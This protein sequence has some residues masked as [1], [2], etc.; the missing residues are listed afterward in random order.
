MSTMLT[1]TCNLH[2]RLAA[3]T[4]YNLVR[5]IGNDLPGWVVDIDNANSY[6]AS[7]THRGCFISASVV[8]IN[9]DESS[10][11]FAI[12]SPGQIFDPFGQL[13][14]MLDQIVQPFQ[15]QASRLQEVERQKQIQQG[16]MCPKCNKP[17]PSGARFCPFDGTPIGHECP[18]CKHV[19]IPTADFCADCG[20]K[21]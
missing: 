4:C 5:Q 13:D 14:K 8:S 21:L 18:K 1:K 17:L 10:I 7:W 11:N 16:T 12:R 15:S 6:T 9:N 3:T 20:A 19:N 2:V